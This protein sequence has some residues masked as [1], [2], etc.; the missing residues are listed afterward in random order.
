MDDAIETDVAGKQEK[1]QTTRKC[2]KCGETKELEMFVKHAASKEGRRHCCKVCIIA[3][4]RTNHRSD[5]VH[6]MVRVPKN[7]LRRYREA[8]TADDRDS[9]SSWVRH[10]L[11]GACDDAGIGCAERSEQG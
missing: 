10:I 7:V 11:R 6:M 4:A 8:A 2:R 9:V 3:Y 5:I 1:K